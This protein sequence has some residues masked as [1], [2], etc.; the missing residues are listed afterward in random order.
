MNETKLQAESKDQYVLSSLS[1]A[2]DILTELANHPDLGITE[3]SK[4]LGLG[5]SSIFRMLYTMEKKGFVQKVADSRYAL[6]MKLT[7]LGRAA[8]N[9]SDEYQTIHYIVEDLAKVSGVAA[10]LSILSKDCSMIF[11]DSAFGSTGMQFRADRGSHYAAYCSGGGKMLLSYLLD[12]PQE[13]L[14]YGINLLP[15]TSTTIT[16][17]QSLRSALR[18][19]RTQGWSMDDGEGETEL[20]CY[21]MPVFAADGRCLCALSVSGLR[22]NMLEN[23]EKYFAILREHVSSLQLYTDT[24]D[25]YLSVYDRL[26]L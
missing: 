2:L 15:R 17:V 23:R 11:A 5:K 3:L 13:E 25:R 7:I 19:I 10:Y 26:A 16:N 9:H 22:R 6:G 14:L 12:T 20:V 24:L 1:N 4:R 18:E 8:G 21:A